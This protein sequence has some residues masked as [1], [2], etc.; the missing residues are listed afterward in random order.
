MSLREKQSKFALLVSHLIQYI[1][2]QGYEVTLGEAWRHPKT[3][4]YLHSVGKGVKNS[5]HEQKLAIDLNLFKDG[6]YLSSTEDH[7]QF[8]R[9]WES[10]D[11]ECT[12][13][14]D[15]KRKDG[16]HYSMYEK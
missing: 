7:E 12:W 3:A 16:N 15:F 6:V 4:D 8:G 1:Y 14:G 13:G 2:D 10:L 5:Y 9:Y 11:P